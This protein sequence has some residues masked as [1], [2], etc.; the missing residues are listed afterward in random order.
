[1]IKSKLQKN[2]SDSISFTLKNEKDEKKYCLG[3][4]F[5][6]SVY[7]HFD[8]MYLFFGVTVTGNYIPF[9]VMFGFIFS[10]D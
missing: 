6:Q 4:N 5:C 9:G 8:S 1:V 10:T 7:L 3:L 2:I